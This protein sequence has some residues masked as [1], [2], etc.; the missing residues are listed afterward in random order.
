LTDRGI[1]EALQRN[2]RRAF[3]HIKKPCQL[4]A[5]ERGGDMS[6]KS[7]SGAN[8][9]N[10]SCLT[11]ISGVEPGVSALTAR[12]ALPNPNRGSDF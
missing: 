12:R 5:S 8:K 11:G 4:Q 1:I 2:R 3:L 9:P 6:M 7:F 10:L